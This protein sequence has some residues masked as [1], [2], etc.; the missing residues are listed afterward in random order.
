M[1]ASGG[2]GETSLYAVDVD[3]IHM[4]PVAGPIQHPRILEYLLV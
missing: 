1:T 3:K 4:W 2:F